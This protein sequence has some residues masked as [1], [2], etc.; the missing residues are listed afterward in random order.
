MKARLA[1]VMWVL[2]AAAFAA[3]VIQGEYN[4]ACGNQA[5]YDAS[6]SKVTAFGVQ[7]AAMSSGNEAV[8]LIG[9][10]AGLYSEDMFSCVGIG[11]KPLRSARNNT[12]C[13][14][15][16]RWAMADSYN[17]DRCV[18]IG[19]QDEMAAPMR[20]RSFVTWI[21]GQI[22][23]HP[24]YI[25]IHDTPLSEQ[26]ESMDESTHDWR[27]YGENAEPPLIEL[28]EEDNDG[29]TQKHLYL[30]ADKI[31]LEPY[32][33]R[34]SMF[35]NI[36]T[37]VYVVNG[38]ASG[39]TAAQAAEIDRATTGAEYYVSAATGNDANDGLSIATAKA[40]V[41]A[42]MIAATN[43]GDT[44]C[45]LAGR[46]AWP[47]FYAQ[48]D[49]APRWLNVV[50]MGGADRVVFD[51]ALNN[52]TPAILRGGVDDAY[53]SYF[54]GI[55]FRGGTVPASGDAVDV[56]GVG[57]FSYVQFK[58]CV[59]E[60]INATSRYARAVWTLCILDGC[61]VR[62]CEFRSGGSTHWYSAIRQTLAE[63][64]LLD[65]GTD[66]GTYLSHFSY[67][68]NCHIKCGDVAKLLTGN[69][70]AY[71]FGHKGGFRD[72]TLVV[73]NVWNVGN[74]TL[75]GCLAGIG[76][77][78]NSVK[79]GAFAV[80]EGTLATNRATVADALLDDLR[81]AES[82]LGMYFLG[83]NSRHDRCIRDASVRAVLDTITNLTDAVVFGGTAYTLMS[84]AGGD[85]ARIDAQ[86][87]LD[88]ALQAYTNQAAVVEGEGE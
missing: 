72:C 41:N 25:A 15:I 46:Y 44:V 84:A 40:T 76:T 85:A 19:R 1:A 18:F 20:N 54:T 70:A 10:G 49:G 81:P 3:A 28:R 43:A 16:G 14:A 35:T 51:A 27:Y 38:Q 23:V 71:S 8:A 80:A 24:G 82:N 47:Q 66:A 74:E 69:T 7:A 63:D 62:D 75:W 64:T 21:N 78:T 32:A 22:V 9:L 30:R 29:I 58:D 56:S 5:G 77:D 53:L 2:A 52:G 11:G 65:V 83:Y 48:K 86:A 37:S 36:S 87:R 39:L 57:C 67:F 79:P 12:D 55:T 73:S 31:H 6:G 4:T 13:I 26:D 34:D 59:F 45:V 42:A 60:G 61:R 33:V 88:A 17:C 68:E 50:G